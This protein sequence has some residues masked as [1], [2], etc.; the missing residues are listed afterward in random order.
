MLVM[1]D[2][3]KVAA[4]DAMTGAELWQ[5]SEGCGQYGATS[6]FGWGL[7]VHNRTILVN[8]NIGGSGEVSTQWTGVT[9]G[10]ARFLARSLMPRP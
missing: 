2:A 6:Y 10:G 7:A 5:S 9:S 1:T 4:F 3:N 8:C